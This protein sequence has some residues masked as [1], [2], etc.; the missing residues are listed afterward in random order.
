MA[1][2]YSPSTWEAEVGGLLWVQTQLSLHSEFKASVNYMV[3][4]CLKKQK[5]NKTKGMEYLR[6]AMK[7]YNEPVLQTLC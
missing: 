5:Q 2:T 4:S 6:Y 3:R 1:R 7:F